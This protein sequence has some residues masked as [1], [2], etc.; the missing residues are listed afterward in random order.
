MKSGPVYRLLSTVYR[1]PSTVY[2]LPSSVYLLTTCFLI[3]IRQQERG[4]SMP[5]A[6]R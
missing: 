6:W 5:S 4:V 2:R 3:L 1:L